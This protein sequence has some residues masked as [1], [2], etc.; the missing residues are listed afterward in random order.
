MKDLLFFAAAG[1]FNGVFGQDANVTASLTAARTTVTTS[2]SS[3]P[4]LFSNE[5]IQLTNAV[6]DEVAETIQ[7]DTI[8]SL[9]SFGTSTNPT[10]SKTTKRS[11]KPIPGDALWPADSIWKIF[12]ILLGGS[13][14]RASP[15]AASCYPD[16]PEYDIDTCNTI[17]AEWRSS[18]LQ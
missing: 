2:V 7:N 14:I 18:D 16:W 1:A 4:P 5:A 17:T 10:V 13:L 15:L 11:C 8:S 6:L 9:F 3:A 12:D